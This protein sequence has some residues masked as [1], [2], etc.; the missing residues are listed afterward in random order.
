MLHQRAEPDPEESLV[1]KEGGVVG[2]AGEEAG[3]LARGHVLSVL[4]LVDLVEQVVI[5]ELP[6]G[7]QRRGPAREQATPSLGGRREDA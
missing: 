1:P 4:P 2:G 3:G 5:D 7:I 6:L